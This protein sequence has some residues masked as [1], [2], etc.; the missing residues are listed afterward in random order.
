MKNYILFSLVK[1]AIA[2]HTQNSGQIMGSQ[3]QGNGQIIR[4]AADVE[5]VGSW[6]SKNNGQIIGSWGSRTNGKI[7]EQ[8]G[9]VVRPS[10]TT[11]ENPIIRGETNGQGQ[12][13]SFRQNGLIRPTET[14]EQRTGSW[15]T[16]TNGQ[17]IEQ[18]GSVIR[19][20]RTAVENPMI[21]RGE[22]NVRQNGLIIRGNGS[23]GQQICLQS[24]WTVNQN[25]CRCEKPACR[26]E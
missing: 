4:S 20:S 17:I 16:R 14:N 21:I 22:T 23:C 10:R 18:Q 5:T 6:R 26:S 8:G 15:G 1:L 12:G 19:T 3:Q 2:D 7:I 25:T 24:G 11:I 13:Q 9:S